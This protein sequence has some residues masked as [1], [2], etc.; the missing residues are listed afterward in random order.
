[1]FALVFGI[2]GSTIVVIVQDLYTM[3]Q[4]DCLF[5]SLEGW[6]CMHRLL[7]DIVLLYCHMHVKYEDRVDRFISHIASGFL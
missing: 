4:Q 7:K 1:M 6:N 3:I 2:V 5:S